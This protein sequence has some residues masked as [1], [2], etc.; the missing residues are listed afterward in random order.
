MGGFVEDHGAAFLPEGFQMLPPDLFCG[1]QEPFKAEPAGGQ[2]GNGKP[3][4]HGAGTGDGR[5]HDACFGAGTDQVLAG[6]RNGRGTGVG[7]Q[8][9]VFT[10]Q[11]PL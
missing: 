6:V 2:A 8:G 7:Y 10:A 1:G 5:N 4:D 3:G 11:Y 9:A